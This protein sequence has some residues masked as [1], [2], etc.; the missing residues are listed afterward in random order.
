MFTFLN[1]STHQLQQ[2]LKLHV[3]F[4]CHVFWDSILGYARSWLHEKLEFRSRCFSLFYFYNV[5]G[6]ICDGDSRISGTVRRGSDAIAFV[7]GRAINYSATGNKSRRD[8]AEV[9]VNK[10]WNQ[11][12]S[13]HKFIPENWKV[14]MKFPS[15]SNESSSWKLQVSESLN[16]HFSNSRLRFHRE[17]FNGTPLSGF[18]SIFLS[19]RPP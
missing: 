8:G 18:Y 15:P 12:E 16:L 14:N 11:V 17:M 10:S 13:A 5:E 4:L 9:K 6:F 19:V 3:L 2:H 1:P 7:S